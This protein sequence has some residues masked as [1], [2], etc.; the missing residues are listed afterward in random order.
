MRTS[1][2]ECAAIGETMARKLRFC[3]RDEL[4]CV[5]VPQRGWSGIDK[6]GGP[7]WDPAADTALVDA[8]TG[9]LR[10][11]KIPV[12]EVDGHINDPQTVKV[13]VDKLHEMV[14][15]SQK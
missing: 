9:G 1:A 13:M 7:F 2:D 15:A 10:D 12:L 5:V 6:T 14:I 3:G 11:S 8:L 4:I